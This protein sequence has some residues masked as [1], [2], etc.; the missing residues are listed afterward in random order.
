MI[1]VVEVIAVLLVEVDLY[2]AGKTLE[3]IWRWKG[4]GVTRYPLVIMLDTVPR[5]LRV[6]TR[7][8]R[9]GVPYLSPSLH[10]GVLPFPVI[11][12]TE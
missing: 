2:T 7:G 9:Y 3:N 4:R 1:L 12:V 5:Y 11:T 6:D 10:P 8:M